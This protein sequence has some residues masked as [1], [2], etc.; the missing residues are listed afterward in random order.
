MVRYPKL[1]W[2]MVTKEACSD[3]KS[4]PMEDNEGNQLNGIVKEVGDSSV[5]MDFN[6][7]M[8]G[9]GLYFT[10]H[11]IDVRDATEEE[12]EH[13]HVHGPDSEHDHQ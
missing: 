1:V 6:H 3:G 11:I 8:A 12:V 5:K 7:P 9:K 10:G 13:G 2:W 4:I